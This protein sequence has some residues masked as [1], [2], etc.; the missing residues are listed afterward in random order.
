MGRAMGAEPAGLRT[1]AGVGL[2]PDVTVATDLMLVSDGRVDERRDLGAAL[3]LGEVESRALPASALILRAYQRWGEDCLDRLLGEF[4]FVVWDSRTRTLRAGASAPLA[5]P[6]YF[7]ATS[8]VFAF[9]S[10]ARGL[11]ALPHLRRRVDEEHVARFLIRVDTGAGSFFQDVR[12]L[13]AGQ[14]LTVCGQAPTVRQWWQ[15]DLRRRIEL[16]GDQEYVDAL[17]P[18][19]EKV[20]ADHLSEKDSTGV[21]LSGGLDSGA[22]AAVAAPLLHR[23][24]RRL[25]AYTEVPPAG[26]GDPVFEGRYADETPYVEAL[27][28]LHP[29]VDL[30]LVRDG[31]GGLLDGADRLFTAAEMPFRNAANRGW[32]EAIYARAGA[33]GVGA[34]LS[35][36]Q[37][38]L[39]VSWGGNGLLAELLRRGRPGRALREARAMARAGGHRSTARALL[40]Y[41]VRPLLPRGLNI[42]IG[43]TLGA[44][45]PDPAL[46]AYGSYSL[47][48]PAFVEELDLVRRDERWAVR[49][50][51][52]PEPDVRRARLRTLVTTA[53]INAALFA[54]YRDLF[55]IDI[56]A[57]LADRRLVEFCLGLPE[58]QF[59]RN[60]QDRWLIRRA[61]DGRLPGPTV[62]GRERGL[63][64]A[65]WFSDMTRERQD[66]LAA[67]RRFEADALTRRI[68]DLPRLR[69]LLEHWPEY[70]PTARR[71]VELYRGMAGAALM[72][73]AFLLWAQGG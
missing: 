50:F 28:G 43:A 4:T 30:H 40:G 51:R 19:L 46:G 14:L 3:G 73:G 31:G 67:V 68:L 21:M 32:M 58:T 9:A 18:L 20:V 72:T 56:R 52:V 35:G 37:G 55:G 34:V 2:G 8:E 66:L 53:S 44:D 24:D 15:P 47:I 62:H 49:R 65:N 29:N 39:T 42:A 5:P 6:L 57:P 16:G 71:D 11:F 48:N 13:L 27:A 22:V 70:A 36:D 38:N 60:G 7:H 69:R 23:E 12:R 63:Q 17:E 10:R 59:A 25:A 26:T 33:A 41:G 64:A 61:M 45:R 1:A 54:G